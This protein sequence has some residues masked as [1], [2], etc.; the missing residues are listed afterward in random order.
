[1]R[2]TTIAQIGGASVSR[3]PPAHSRDHAD[4][5]RPAAEARDRPA[6]Q[7]RDHR[8][9]QVGHEDRA[10]QGRGKAVGRRG[11]VEAHIGE[12][13]DEVEQGAE[14]DRVGRDELRVFEMP[15]HLPH[16]GAETLRSARSLARAAAG[17]RPTI[18]P[19]SESTAR[20][21]MRRASRRYRRARPVTKRPAEAA[22]ARPGDV[23]AGD[24]G[25]LGR[26]ATRRRYRRR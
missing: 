19:T 25:D 22:D 15:Q 1:M 14:A 7:R 23:D 16:R 10:E 13:R 24:A 18:A 20:R 9:D 26:P 8:A 2:P 21:E 4:D 6:G 11:E 5:E 12:H 17:R 3:A